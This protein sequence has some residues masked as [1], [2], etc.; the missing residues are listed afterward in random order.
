MIGFA[1]HSKACESCSTA[2]PFPLLGYEGEGVEPF[3]DVEP[4]PLLGY[5]EDEY[6]EKGED[7]AEGE[8]D[9]EGEDDAWDEDQ[10]R[11]A[12]KLKAELEKVSRAKERLV[13]SLNG[14]KALA[15][16]PVERSPSHNSLDDKYRF[17]ISSPTHWYLCSLCFT[18]RN[19][20]F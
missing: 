19:F 2:D 10:E 17:V 7:D 5:E 13:A 8:D 9:M 14:F 12:Q 11:R 20:S 1:D 15:D 6:D 16:V 3:P 4:L 18:A